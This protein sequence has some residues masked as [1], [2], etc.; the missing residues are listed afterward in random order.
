MQRLI[1]GHQII[2]AGGYWDR[3]G[4]YWVLP[5]R[6]VASLGLDNRIIDD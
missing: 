3:D 4:G 1:Q 5:F 2:P 6:E